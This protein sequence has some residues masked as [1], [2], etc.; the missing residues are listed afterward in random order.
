MHY[1]TKKMNRSFVSYRGSIT[2][3]ADML[4]PFMP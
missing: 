3:E 4:P 2:G 1:R